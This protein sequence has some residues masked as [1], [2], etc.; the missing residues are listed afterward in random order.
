[1]FYYVCFLLYYAHKMKISNHIYSL[2]WLHKMDF[3]EYGFDG[4]DST[5]WTERRMDSMVD[6]F[7]GGWIRRRM[8]STQDGYAGIRDRNI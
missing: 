4:I 3:T 1:M 7:D 2:P 6:G 8:D 5:G